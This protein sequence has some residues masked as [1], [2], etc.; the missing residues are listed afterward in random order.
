A[1]GASGSIPATAWSRKVPQEKLNDV[2]L[3]ITT[4]LTNSGVDMERAM[5]DRMLVPLSAYTELTQPM[6]LGGVGGFESVKAYIERNCFASMQGKKFE[7][8]PLPND[9]LVGKGS[10]VT[11][12]AVCY[13]NDEDCV[14][15]DIPQ[16]KIQTMTAPV[17]EGVGAWKTAFGGCIGQVIF[18]RTTTFCYGDGI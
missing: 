6:T 13:R 5:P 16:P 4:I 17:M 11:N 14:Y 10:G 12:R 18:K 8:L 15:I 3:L 9:W 7:I 1:A 2:N